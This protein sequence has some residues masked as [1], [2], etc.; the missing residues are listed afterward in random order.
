MK[1]V[2]ETSGFIKCDIYFVILLF[3]L[4]NTVAMHI[5]PI[6]WLLARSYKILNIQLDLNISVIDKNNYNYI[7][8]KYSKRIDCR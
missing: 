6:Y 2:I 5:L 3:Y 7:L 8:F 1:Q 4:A